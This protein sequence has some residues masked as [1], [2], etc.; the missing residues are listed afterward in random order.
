MRWESLIP[1][2]FNAD[3]YPQGLLIPEN[4]DMNFYSPILKFHHNFADR[5]GPFDDCM[6]FF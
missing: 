3:Q 5:R 1:Y 2:R 6:R 4:N